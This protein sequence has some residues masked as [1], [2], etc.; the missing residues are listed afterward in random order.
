MS[1]WNKIGHID[2]AL[3]ADAR[4]AAAILKWGWGAWEQHKV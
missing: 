1:E 3:A 2:A 4:N